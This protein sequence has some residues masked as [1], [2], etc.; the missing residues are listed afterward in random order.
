PPPGR[1]ALLPPDRHTL[2]VARHAAAGP[3]KLHALARCRGSSR[4]GVRRVLRGP[5]LPRPSH[6]R[7]PR[8]QIGRPSRRQPG[9]LERGGR[10]AA[11]T[12]GGRT[13]PMILAAS[14]WI[15]DP[16]APARSTSCRSFGSTPI[17]F[18][19]TLMPEAIDPLANWSWRTSFWLKTTGR[20]PVSCSVARTKARTPSS[21]T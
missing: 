8:L 7:R 1:R 19:R 10:L 4:G 21:V 5:L 15:Y 6:H 12:T 11:P 9:G 13:S 3:R 20:P 14:G 2:P 16:K 18:I 17:T